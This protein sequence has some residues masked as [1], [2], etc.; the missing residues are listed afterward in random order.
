VAG[1]LRNRQLGPHV[2]D[3]VRA[4]YNAWEEG[5]H[6]VVAKVGKGSNPWTEHYSA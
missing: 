2:H 6:A 5:R 1:P 4:A 3:A